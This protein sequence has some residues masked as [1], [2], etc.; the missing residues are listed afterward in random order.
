M[1][2]RT[3]CGGHPLCTSECDCV[4]SVWILVNRLFDM[5]LYF[6]TVS[7]TL[8]LL[9]G[10]CHCFPLPTLTCAEAK[11]QMEVRSCMLESASSS[12]NHVR[13]VL[14][15]LCA[16]RRPCHTTDLKAALKYVGR[17]MDRAAPPGPHHRSQ[18]LERAGPSSLVS[19]SRAGWSGEQ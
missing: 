9:T 13:T 16:E 5:P 18:Q 10:T 19:V 1:A 17:G 7:S 12:T 8:V 14:Q 3:S 2:R 4:L 15:V 6:C 11:Q